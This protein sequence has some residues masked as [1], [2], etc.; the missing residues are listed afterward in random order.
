MYFHKHKTWFIKIYTSLET[1]CRQGKLGVRGIFDSGKSNFPVFL[2]V[3]LKLVLLQLFT[4]SVRLFALGFEESLEVIYGIF[5][6]N[7]KSV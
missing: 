5:P 1:R 6:S 7:R 4:S 2:I 3:L